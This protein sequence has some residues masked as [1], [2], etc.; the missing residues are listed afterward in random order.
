LPAMRARA[1][2]AACAATLLLVSA[3]GAQAASAAQAPLAA[4]ALAAAQP[5]RASAPVLDGISDQ[6]LP[7][8]S[9]AAARGPLPSL[10]ADPLQGERHPIGMARYV[11]Q[12]DG[13]G[14]S[15]GGAEYEQ[16]L[17]AWLSDV[18]AAGLVRV[19]ALTS[20]GGPLPGPGEYGAEL[21][22]T[23]ARASAIGAPVAWV[24]PWNEPNNQGRAPAPLAASYANVAQRVCAELG[25]G[26][27]AGDFEDAPGA[28][29][30]ERDYER[31]LDFA[32]R[33]WGVHPY[34]AVARRDARSLLALTAGLL[35]GS[36]LWF[37]EVAVAYCRRGAV[38]GEQAQAAEAGYL[39]ALI[40]ALMPAHAFYYGVQYTN[41][42]SGA[43]AA[44]GGEDTQLFGAGGRPRPAAASLLG[45][46]GQPLAAF[47]PALG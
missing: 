28:S 46:A 34:R 1:V 5:P 15:P 11:A 14:A 9:G 10:L 40:A 35:P 16:R 4:Q 12:W 44:P 26:V 8:L 23:L 31:A 24:E 45:S 33:D 30:Y 2:L 7:P 22:A 38:L 18:A 37:T 27:V 42:A 32:P 6:G 41:P 20:Y 29:A 36:R 17:E 47:G 43:C 25:C 19:L 39:H 13:L 21:R 3:L